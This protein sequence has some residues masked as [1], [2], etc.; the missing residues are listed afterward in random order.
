MYKVINQ[1]NEVVGSTNNPRLAVALF[2]LSIKASKSK[3]DCFS[4]VKTV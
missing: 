2:E 3:W 4:I 1:K